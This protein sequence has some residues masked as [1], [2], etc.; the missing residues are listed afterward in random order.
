MNRREKGD[1]AG[2]WGQRREEQARVATVD[3]ESGNRNSNT[4]DIT[5]VELYRS[6]IDINAPLIENNYIN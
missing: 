6:C 2:E 4:Q 5:G 1:E 3:F